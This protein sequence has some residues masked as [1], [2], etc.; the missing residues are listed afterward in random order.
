M[1]M[2]IYYNREGDHDHDGML[3]A[4][5]E[6][7]PILQYIDA[8]ARQGGRRRPGSL[9][10]P[11]PDDYVDE[12]RIRAQAIGVDLPLTPAQARGP[13]P[14]IRPLVLRARV[15]ETVTIHLCND[16]R[17]RHVGIHLVGGGYDVKTDDG[18]EVGANPSSLTEYGTTRTYTWRCDDEGVFPFHDGGN[19]DGGEDGTNVHGLFGALIVEPPG[20]TWRDPVTGRG[21]H[22]VDGTPGF[23]QLDGLHLDVLA[24]GEAGKP[25]PAST[26]TLADGSRWPDPV[27][28]LNQA[29][30]PYS[31]REFVIFF[32]DEPEYVPAHGVLEPDPC[33]H[34]GHG[35]AVHGS[36]TAGDGARHGD[37]GHDDLPIMAVSYRAEPMINRER[38]LWR[39]LRTGHELER[40]V[41][42]EEQHHSSWMFGDPS[43]HLVLR[44]YIG[45][46]VRIR[47]VHAAVKETHVFHLHLYEW[48][49]V[50]G[51]QTSPRIDAI[52]IS[53]QTGHTI[54]PAWGAG[55]RHQVAGDVIWH[56]HLYPHFHEGMWGMFRTFETRQYHWWLD[57]DDAHEAADE[58]L[59]QS[60]GLDDLA[61]DS[62]H[63]I[64]AGRQI[65]RYPDGTRIQQ[66]L[67]LPENPPPNP[68][69]THPGFP[70]YIPGTV[71]QKSPR[72]PWPDRELT[73]AE[74][75]HEGYRL[76][77]NVTS[78][79]GH[80]MPADFD[81]RPVPTDLERLA[82]NDFPV[83]G[84]LFTRNRL[85]EQQQA[86][87]EVLQC[88]TSAEVCHD[89]VV[90]QR[91]IDYN[92]H[93]W[94]DKHGH[95]YYL[96]ADGDPAA[97]PGPHEPLFFRA[98][99]GQILNLTLRNALPQTIEGTEF[100]HPFPPCPD[101]PWE[102]ECAPHVHMVK[103]DPICAD[104][105]SVGWNY[106]SG[107]RFGRKMVYRWWADQE[108]GTIFFHDHLFA[109]YRQKH[110]LFGALIVEPSGSKFYHHIEDD[111]E[112]VSGLQALIKVPSRLTRHD[113]EVEGEGE[114]VGLLTLTATIDTSGE[115]PEVIDT[116]IVEVD[117]SAEETAPT[118]SDPA[119]HDGPETQTAPED[120]SD[121]EERPTPDWFRE[122]CI[123]IADFIPMWDG[124]GRPLNPP[125][126]PGGHGDQGVMALNYRNAPLRERPGDPAYWFDSRVHGDPATTVYQAY[127]DDPIWFRVLQGSHEE[128]H[129]F[130]VHGLRWQRFRDNL[131]ST[132]RNQQTTG[133]AEAFT[134][135]NRAP[136]RRGDYLYKLSGADDLWLGCWGIVRAHPR[137]P[138]AGDRDLLG[139]GP[140][141]EAYS[142]APDPALPVRTFGVTATPRR[143]YYRD[144]LVDPFGLVYRLDSVQPPGGEPVEV[145]SLPEDPTAAVEPLVLWCREGDQVRVILTND[146]PDDME[147][148]PFAP[149]VP[150]ERER[151]VSRHVSMH[152][153][154]VAYDVRESDGANVGVNPV[155][156]AAPGAAPRTYTWDT[157]HPRPDAEETLGPVLLQDM[158]DVRNHRHHGLIGALVIV[159]RG[160]SP[161]PVGPGESTSS[162]EEPVWHGTRVT[163]RPDGSS[164]DDP[165]RVEHM[166]A[167]I[168]DGLRLFLNGNLRF[169]LPDPPGEEP[170]EA[171]HEDQGQK[172][173]NYRSEPRGQFDPQNSEYCLD[174]DEPATP[175]WC[176]PRG[177]DVEFHLVGALDK[178][179]AY[180]FTIHGV[181]W[182]EHRF[183]GQVPMVSAESAISSGSGRTFRFTPAYTGD[184][185]YRTGVLKWALG[186]G[187]WGILRV[188]DDTWPCKDEEKQSS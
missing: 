177:S 7:V 50:V 56:C 182:P 43:D 149:E 171:E 160:Y 46:R 156:T 116:E 155:Q 22:D 14:S 143:L 112:I 38:T 144:D 126:Q 88:N 121:G 178:P 175:V 34:R 35:G 25:V 167:L 100:D 26:R 2:T 16:I 109:N 11:D 6:N 102:G 12:A 31:Y 55:N 183:Q 148:E 10:A 145:P 74:V 129:S 173:I 44:A 17:D 75:E 94:H 120:T 165:D 124:R 66:L 110:G 92:D 51:D 188:T 68:T 72:P 187:M 134:F 39:L 40:P 139:F 98:Q 21:S 86:E 79:R 163:V 159:P 104:G 170:G 32:H 69:R 84:E 71:R 115:R 174:D 168:Q 87:P 108:F 106:M 150:V 133:I 99:H 89:L 151:P 54:E 23:A 73:A 131:D 20:T 1:Q 70:L 153:D 5:K 162:S 146:L 125:Q 28:H 138:A 158:A 161:Y 37:A 49:A 164:A 137:P 103:F 154:L 176:V 181:T 157:R 166:V 52:S 152:A 8:L 27:E 122:F 184:H 119:D 13:H 127:E 96:E 29:A 15:N 64:Y 53:P 117:S 172:G 111:R 179:R 91:R 65:G 185:A 83:P 77:C 186:Q 142:G 135:I 132:V 180:S 33:A 9:P 85:T 30:D 140:R 123:G 62:D 136:V 24:P 36:H 59:R 3:F 78:L 19:F 81:Y 101:R 130:Q 45:D 57:G 80:D 60:I 113:P 114:A 169:P 105:A 42:N 41:L 90:A 107:A 58:A 118:G 61:L 141:P 97:Q 47:F 63:P 147:P 76:P 82:F 93:G 95:L 128:S 48:H 18:A 67:P 4:L